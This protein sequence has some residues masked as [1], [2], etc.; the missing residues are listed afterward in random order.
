[1]NRREKTETLMQQVLELH[2]LGVR[3]VDIAVQL[4]I[5]KDQVSYYKKKLGVHKY[6]VKLTPQVKSRIYALKREGCSFNEIARRIGVCATT[7]T[8][9]LRRGDTSATPIEVMLKKPVNQF[10]TRPWTKAGAPAAAY[11]RGDKHAG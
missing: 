8:R 6:K 4:G 7:I 2:Q 9:F 1:M 11:Q 3:R 10:L 5:S